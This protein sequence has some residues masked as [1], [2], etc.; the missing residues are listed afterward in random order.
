M[1]GLTEVVVCDL[2]L[3]VLVRTWKCTTTENG[4]L[5]PQPVDVLPICGQ[6]QTLLDDSPS[7]VVLQ[8][9]QVCCV[10][11]HLSHANMEVG[12]LEVGHGLKALL[13]YRVLLIMNREERDRHLC[14]SGEATLTHGGE[15]DECR[16]LNGA[17]E[18]TA[19]D[20]P[21]PWLRGVDL[22]HI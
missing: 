17:V 5:M 9:E 2:Q 21:H 11:G 8:V 20:S 22:P 4:I 14:S 1:L 10:L 18:L 13:P 7:G 19:N 12:T 15:G 3:T 16:L 6:P